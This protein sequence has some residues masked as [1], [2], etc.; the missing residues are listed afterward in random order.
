MAPTEKE[1]LL[2][3]FGVTEDFFTPNFVG[4]SVEYRFDFLNSER[5]DGFTVGIFNSIGQTAFY[6]TV[7][8]ADVFWV[9]QF[10]CE[11]YK[12]VSVDITN[13]KFS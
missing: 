5:L 7:N 2:H 12:N 13:I 6:E 8:I 3:K 4:I 11:S 9:I 1:N 10:I